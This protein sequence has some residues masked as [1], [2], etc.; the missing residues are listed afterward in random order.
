MACGLACT[1]NLH[2]LPEGILP[3]RNLPSAGQKQREINQNRKNRIEKRER[4]K[5]VKELLE[6]NPLQQPQ[7]KIS[8]IN[9]SSLDDPLGEAQLRSFLPEE[10]ANRSWL[11][12]PDDDAIFE[13]LEPVEAPSIH[14]KQEPGV[15]K[16]PDIFCLQDLC[17][18]CAQKCD[19]EVSI[20]G[21]TDYAEMIAECMPIKIDKN[22]ELPAKIC[23]GCLKTVKK[24]HALRNKCREADKTL[25]GHLK[26]Q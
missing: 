17:R 19:D 9:E 22:D 20:F 21:D 10:F 12:L 3:S 26:E 14:I 4:K 6:Q 7:E 16:D 24:I 23:K 8:A 15:E 18:I 11:A 1:C 13:V 2:R 25:R 5:I